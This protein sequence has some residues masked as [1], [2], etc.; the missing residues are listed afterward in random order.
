MSKICRNC[1]TVAE[2]KVAKRGSIIIS[3]ILWMCFFIPGMIY[4]AWRM[5]SKFEVCPS[6]GSVAIV[7][8]DTPIGAKMAVESGHAPEPA[9]QGSSKAEDFGRRIGR[10]FAKR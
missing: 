3:F 7:P 5:T 2:P 1:G 10:M 6:C 4:S 9:Y 8:L